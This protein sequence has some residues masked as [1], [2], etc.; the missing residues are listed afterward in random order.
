MGFVSFFV[1]TGPAPVVDNPPI[2]QQTP[3]PLLTT[4]NG[5]GY[6]FH[7]SDK[8]Q[9]HAQASEHQITGIGELLSSARARRGL[10]LQQ[11][12]NETKIPRQFLEA[13]EQ[14]RLEALRGGLYRRAHVR[15]YAQACPARSRLAPSA[16]AAPEGIVAE[17]PFL[18]GRANG[19]SGC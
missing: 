18:G 14:D 8:S 15:M 10:T 9:S 19:P 13:V 4:V 5:N 11:V 16:G 2:G 7:P 17:R 6:T 3:A 1:Q 12:S